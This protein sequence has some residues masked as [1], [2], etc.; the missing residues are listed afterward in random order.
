MQTTISIR[1]FPAT[2]DLSDFPTGVWQTGDCSI[3]NWQNHRIDDWF[4]YRKYLFIITHQVP[5]ELLSIVFTL[6]LPS[7][8]GIHIGNGK[9]KWLDK[10]IGQDIPIHRY[11]RRFVT[12]G[13]FLIIICIYTLSGRAKDVLRRWNTYQFACVFPFQSG[14]RWSYL[15]CRE[16]QPLWTPS[17]LSWVSDYRGWSCLRCTISEATL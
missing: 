15:S 5:W 17:A 11:R 1:L 10:E 7:N 4:N 6:L 12:R 16:G 14:F 2:P 13:F 8:V 3:Y 9:A